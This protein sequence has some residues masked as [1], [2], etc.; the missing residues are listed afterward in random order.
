[1]SDIT[2]DLVVTFKQV[3]PSFTVYTGV[4]P[5]GA[6]RPAIAIYNVAFENDRVLSG[7]KTKNRSTWRITLSDSVVNLQTSI[8]QILLNDE[9]VNEY[10]QRLFIDLTLIESKALTEPYQR[11]FFD[12]SVYPK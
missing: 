5:E 10:F 12:V 4:I 11:A 7:K 9:L 1:M 8:D 3:L 6:T 2:K